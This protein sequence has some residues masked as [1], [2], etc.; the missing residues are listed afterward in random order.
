MSKR[1]SKIEIYSLA[2]FQKADRL[3]RIR[4]HMIEPERFVLNDQDE[5]YYL[6][7]QE[8][9][10]LVSNEVR[11]AVAIRLIQDKVDGC[12]TY[13]KAN[14]V[15][16]D[17]EALF[18][19]F[20][21][22]NRTIQRARIIEKMYLFAEKAESKAIW[23][24]EEGLEYVD[25]EWLMLAQKFYREA[26]EME[27]LN[28]IEESMLDADDIEI[29]EIEITSDPQAFLAMQT[30]IEDVEFDDYPDDPEEGEQDEE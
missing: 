13:Y 8:A 23:T 24:D 27:G 21:S 6:Q 14:R 28:K 11:E 22:K 3:D 10:L 29:P 19:P 16:R 4:M 12:E 7:L 26:A 17:V 5:V 18:A 15:L 2:D 30:G 1:P 20:L 25:Q 9:W